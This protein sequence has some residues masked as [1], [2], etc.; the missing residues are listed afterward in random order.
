MVGWDAWYERIVGVGGGRLHE[1]SWET[2]PPR[3]TVEK[4]EGSVH[5]MFDA[6]GVL[7]KSF[8]H[9]LLDLSV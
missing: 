4:E 3:V 1:L 5:V 8:P 9:F 7:E 6:H 2:R